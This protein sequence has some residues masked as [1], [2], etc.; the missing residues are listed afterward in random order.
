MSAIV[1]EN[2][3]M[4]TEAMIGRWAASLDRDEWPDGWQNVGDVVDGKLP[5]SGSVTLSIKIPSAMKRAIEREA[6]A[7]G[8]S[9]GAYVRG[10]IADSL[11]AIA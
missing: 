5:G 10:V 9:T 2:G 8:K 4:V 11:M 3:Q 7:E 6:K 1:A